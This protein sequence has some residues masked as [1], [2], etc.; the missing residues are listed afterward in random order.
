[1]YDKFIYK[2]TI[3]DYEVKYQELKN[4]KISFNKDIF[5]KLNFPKNYKYYSIEEVELICELVSIDY[6]GLENIFIAEMSIGIREVLDKMPSVREILLAENS[7]ELEQKQA[8]FKKENEA[9]INADAEKLKKELE[10]TAEMQKQTALADLVLSQNESITV[11]GESYY[12]IEV[13]GNIAYSLMFSMWFE[14]EGNAMSSEKLE[15]VT[16]ERIRK[17]CEKIAEN[18]TNQ[19]K[20]KSII[21]RKKFKAK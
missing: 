18:E 21:Y 6:A 10:L 5:K 4:K 17:Y 9:I 8:E 19:I 14:L 7:K 13:T 3:N 20:H 16:F 11:K 15:R 12:E 1:L 2:L